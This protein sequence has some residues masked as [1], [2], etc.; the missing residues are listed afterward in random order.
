MNRA[1]GGGLARPGAEA[2]K[3]DAG[4]VR[5]E[6]GEMRAFVAAVVAVFVIA[7]VA[8]LVLDT[9]GASSAEVFSSPDVRL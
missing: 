4:P 7:V 8:G 9:V 2:A 6:E 3:C 5:G 1:A